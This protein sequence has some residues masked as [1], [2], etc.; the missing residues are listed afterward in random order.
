M[1]TRQ[2][3]SSNCILVGH[4][5]E[6]ISLELL[7]MLSASE[8]RYISSARALRMSHI[9]IFVVWNVYI[10][11]PLTNAPKFFGLNPHCHCIKTKSVWLTHWKRMARMRQCLS[12]RYWFRSDSN[13]LLFVVHA[14]DCFYIFHAFT[15]IYRN[16]WIERHLI[17]DFSWLLSIAIRTPFNPIPVLCFQINYLNIFRTCTGKKQLANMMTT[18]TSI[19]AAFLRALNWPIVLELADGP[20]RRSNFNSNWKIC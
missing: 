19:F 3:N 2:M 8:N 11:L 7:N 5:N 4:V 1:Q 18:A 16:C 12:K 13:Q 15:S 6:C 20:E 9:T 14:Q 17:I 10:V